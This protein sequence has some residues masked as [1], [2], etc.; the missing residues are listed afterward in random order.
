MYEADYKKL[1]LLIQKYCPDFLIDKYPRFISFLKAYY[2]W[3]T[4]VK[5]FNPWRVTSHLIEWGDID[6]TLDEF[7]DYF[8]EE[9][10]NDLNVNFNGDI[11]KFLK[12]T[13]E[14]YSSR[15]TPESFRFLLQILSGNTGEIFYPNQF[16]MKSSDGVWVTD[17]NIFVEYTD[18][19][20]NSFIST[21]VKG[22]YTGVTGV[23]ET[24]ETHFNYL[25]QERFLK[26]YISDLTGDL[27]DDK[28]IFTNNEK[29]VELS[30][31]KTVKSVN[32]VTGG[33]NYKIDDSLSIPGDPT[34][35]ARVNRINTGIIDS[36]AILN[37]GEGYSV[38]DE[39]IVK[40]DEF[41]YYYANAKIYVDEVDPD[42][43]AITSLDIRYPGY[44]FFSLP[45]VESIKS[46]VHDSSTMQD[47]QI[48][49]ISDGC[50][51]ISEVSVITAEIN[52]TDEQE[53]TITSDTGVGALVKINT[54][55]IF[56]SI[57]YYYKP[58]S[59]LSDDFKLQ[60]SDY[61]QEYSY[62]VKSSLSLDGVLSQFSEYRDIFKKLVHPAGFK[63][64]NSFIL[65]NHI[66]I[67]T[68]YINSTITLGGP[69]TFIDLVNWIEMVSSWNRIINDDIIFQHRFSTIYDE[70]NTPIN[71]YRHSGGEYVHST[72]EITGPRSYYCWS[73]D[74]PY[75]FCL[76]T[77]SDTPS[78]NDDVYGSQRN[79]MIYKV[80][81]IGPSYSYIKFKYLSEGEWINLDIQFDRN[82]TYDYN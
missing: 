2:D 67:N 71:Y 22:I 50:G 52:Y 12:H 55:N 65:S 75:L 34:F 53:L 23:V 48:E 57:P 70:L 28:V 61:W 37:G 68:L 38:G 81:S 46:A 14:F 18:E 63:L 60:D 4:N 76:Y 35:I 72:I 13:K 8:K 69:S 40:A 47:A 3:S 64:F 9:Y 29:S 79:H 32:I 74:V 59:F 66:D 43:G 82:S 49:F 78:V 58:G 80:A 45:Y 36:Y 31:Y 10:L 51:S 62:E 54:G 73:I 33:N 1:S 42:T 16:L 21:T 11:R 41:D 26:V 6:E 19:L 56:T 44:G 5:E 15:G 30:L 7:I 27:T 39:I 77:T 25:T 20:D 17:Q 24:I